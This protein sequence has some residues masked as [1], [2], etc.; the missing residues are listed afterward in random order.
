MKL[1]N[2]RRLEADEDRIAALRDVLCRHQAC[3]PARLSALRIVMRHRLGI[4]SAASS[5]DCTN[6]VTAT[7]SRKALAQSALPLPFTLHADLS[8]LAQHGRAVLCRHN[9]KPHPPRRFQERR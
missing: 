5:I 3:G 8:F 6:P 9:P 7:A 4:A 1:A 2:P